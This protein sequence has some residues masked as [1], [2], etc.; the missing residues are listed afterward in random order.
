MIYYLPS[1]S[2]QVLQ[3]NLAL[4][5]QMGKYGGSSEGRGAD[6]GLSDFMFL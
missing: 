6:H 1:P 4:M 5:L 2:S 3:I